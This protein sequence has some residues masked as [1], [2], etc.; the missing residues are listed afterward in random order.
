[1]TGEFVAATSCFSPGVCMSRLAQG[2]C[3]SSPARS[4]YVAISFF[5]AVCVLILNWVVLPLASCTWNHSIALE[6]TQLVKERTYRRYKGVTLRLTC[7]AG[8][9]LAAR[10]V[11]LLSS[12]LAA[13]TLQWLL[14]LLPH[15][16]D[17]N[18]IFL[19]FPVLGF[20]RRPNTDPYC[21]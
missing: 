1:M 12:I 13:G 10:G 19:Y 18:T 4:Q 7:S 20:L 17:Q 14:L 8:V 5:S 3:M 16:N 9:P 11:G 21:P 15:M 2:T 6:R